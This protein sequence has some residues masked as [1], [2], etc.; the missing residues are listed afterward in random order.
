MVYSYIYIYLNE[1][2]ILLTEQWGESII[3]FQV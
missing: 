3:A 2:W 1:D